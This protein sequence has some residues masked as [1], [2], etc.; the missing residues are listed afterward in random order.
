M[1]RS[2]PQTLVF[3]GPT[4]PQTQIVTLE[5]WV[6]VVLTQ[7]VPDAGTTQG[8]VTAKGSYDGGTSYATIDGFSWD[9]TVAAEQAGKILPRLFVRG[10]KL[11]V[12]AESVAAGKTVKV[13]IKYAEN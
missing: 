4:T 12:K 1:A 7:I 5:D 2:D 11:E 9:G 3:T 10:G 6:R 8:K 13:I